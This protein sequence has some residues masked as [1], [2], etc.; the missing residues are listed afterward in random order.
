VPTNFGIDYKGGKPQL[1]PRGQGAQSRKD[2]RT[3]PLRQ[4]AKGNLM[5]AL[6]MMNPMS[7]LLRFSNSAMKTIRGEV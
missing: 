6:N 5:P 7:Q 1:T 4:A 3:D 2:E